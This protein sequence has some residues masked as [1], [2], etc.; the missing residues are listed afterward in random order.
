MDSFPKTDAESCQRKHFDYKSTIHNSNRFT[1]HPEN[2]KIKLY[3]FQEKLS[4]RYNHGTI[5]RSPLKR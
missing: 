3:Y 5:I 2:F 4:L 1:G